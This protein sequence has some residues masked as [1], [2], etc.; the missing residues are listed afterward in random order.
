MSQQSPQKR[1]S[2]EPAPLDGQTIREFIK[3]QQQQAQNEAKELE[4]KQKEVD[5]AFRFSMRSLELQAEVE[6]SRPSEARKGL[7]TIGNYIILLVIVFLVFFD[8]AFT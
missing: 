3:I 5:N 1:N 8:F 7:T 4:I 6:K 2:S